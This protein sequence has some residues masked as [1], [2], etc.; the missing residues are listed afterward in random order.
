MS[1]R[2]RS[3][4]SSLRS[5]TGSPPSRRATKDVFATG[6]PGGSNGGGN[7]IASSASYSSGSE[8]DSSATLSS[9]DSTLSS[10]ASSQSRTSGEM[11][12]VG[13]SGEPKLSNRDKIKRQLSWRSAS[14]R[15][16]KEAKQKRAKEKEREK[17]KEGRKRG[18]TKIFKSD[19]EMKEGKLE[20]LRQAGE[21]AYESIATSLT[22]IERNIEKRQKI[23]D[24]L[25]EKVKEMSLYIHRFSSV[26][27]T[28][29][30]TVAPALGSSPSATAGAGLNNG[31]SSSASP[32][33]FV[34]QS[35]SS[36]L[37]KTI[38]TSTS[39]RILPTMERV[40]SAVWE[41]LEKDKLKRECK[42]K[43]E[44]LLMWKQINNMA[45]LEIRCKLGSMK[46]NLAET[47]SIGDAFFIVQ[48][49][50]A[51]ERYL[52]EG[53]EEQSDSNNKSGKHQLLKYNVLRSHISNGGMLGNGDDES[54]ASEAMDHNPRLSSSLSNLKARSLSTGQKQLRMRYLELLDSIDQ[55]IEEIRELLNEVHSVLSKGN[56]SLSPYSIVS[57]ASIIKDIKKIWESETEFHEFE[58][59]DNTNFIYIME[60]IQ[61]LPPDVQIPAEKLNKLTKVTLITIAELSQEF[62][63]AQN[64]VTNDQSIAAAITF[65]RKLRS[66]RKFL[67]RD[68]TS[69]SVIS[70][71]NRA[72]RAGAGGQVMRLQAL[73]KKEV[74]TS[75]IIQEEERTVKE[76][77]EQ[78]SDAN[79]QRHLLSLSVRN[80]DRKIN[81]I[82]KSRKMQLDG[83]A[84]ED[85]SLEQE[86]EEVFQFFDESKQ[87]ENPLGNAK[88]KY[89]HFVSIIRSQPQYLSRVVRFISLTDGDNLVETITF[90]LFS[91]LCLGTEEALL[92]SMVSRIMNSEFQRCKHPRDF[93][94]GTTFVSRLISSYTKRQSGRLH[95]VQTLKEALSSIMNDDK[96]DVELDPQKLYIEMGEVEEEEVYNMEIADIRKMPRVKKKI[97]KHQN[98]LHWLC[99]YV[100][101]TIIKGLSTMPFGMRWL[102][103]QLAEMMQEKFPESTLEDRDILLGSYIFLRFYSPAIITP[104]FYGILTN[105]NT[106]SLRVRRNLLH[107]AKVLQNLANRCP[108]GEK[109]PF[110]VPMNVF[111]KDNQSVLQF[112][113]DKLINV[114]DP[115]AYF[116][117]NQQVGRSEQT[118]TISPNELYRLVTFVS[119]KLDDVATDEEDGDLRSV[120]QE[121]LPVPQLLPKRN[122][123]YLLLHITNEPPSKGDEPDVNIREKLVNDVKDK[124]VRVLHLLAPLDDI[125]GDDEDD[126]PLSPKYMGLGSGNELSPT[127]STAIRDAVNEESSASDKRRRGSSSAGSAAAAAAKGKG[128]EVEEE[129]EVDDERDKDDVSAADQR[130]RMSSVEED[131]SDDDGGDKERAVDGEGKGIDDGMTEAERRHSDGQPRWSHMNVRRMLQEVKKRA[132]TNGVGIVTMMS[133]TGDGVKRKKEEQDELLISLDD[134]IY[135][136]KRLPEE[137]KASN[138]AHLLYQMEQDYQRRRIYLSFLCTEKI[139]MLQSLEHL[140]SEVERLVD[141]KEIYTEYLK[142]VQLKAFLARIKSRPIIG[143]FKYKIRDLAK[144]GVITVSTREME[145]LSTEGYSA[146]SEE[147]MGGMPLRVSTDRGAGGGKEGRTWLDGVVKMSC[148][149][150]GSINLVIH[151]ID[152]PPHFFEMHLS[153]LMDE[154]LTN[155]TI[156]YNGVVFDLRKVI[157]FINNNLTG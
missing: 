75:S 133:I 138:Y 47:R 142:N 132:K 68:V 27:I 35:S 43:E 89:E 90:S 42:T 67:L 4:T 71:L 52:E 3:L 50:R 141:E 65:A 87:Q 2:K 78:I 25:K 115:Q 134:L 16:K 19:K 60:R 51:L 74:A 113:F 20:N 97:R 48:S 33:P 143:P 88:E 94:R 117:K 72:S 107:I 40:N 84:E 152:S 129:Q 91:D 70:N 156:T 12:A 80:L 57:L 136:L 127:K 103:K 76:M 83:R 58:R 121:L 38:Q 101:N 1:F 64:N 81:I 100:L 66:I 120:V 150:P 85:E 7:G 144:V 149:S 109:E 128:K 147:Q 13:T 82:I 22:D 114:G 125:L 154:L 18:A 21:T 9:S 63:D 6:S 49:F 45:L 96:L 130:R 24:Q 28:T 155:D 59:P 118:I 53:E 140:Q 131:S 98:K 137:Y 14:S 111:L 11:A 15:V 32:P 73:L 31:S 122:N 77:Q 26:T 62:T 29:T 8:S 79:V 36:N 157:H 99:K 44:R 55:A 153:K 41:S 17:E 5:L 139:E 104:E 95:L 61:Q 112:Y 46:Q 39:Y 119:S 108:F 123:K 30:A 106:L 146:V 102:A 54:G 148:T 69:S 86:Y 10:S 56:S 37:N 110:M 116:R 124:L 93:L 23:D 151:H 105:A 126:V 145:G 34:A 92:L 135:S